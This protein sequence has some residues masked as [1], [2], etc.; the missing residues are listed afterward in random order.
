[1]LSLQN[2]EKLGKI[3]GEHGISIAFLILIS[4]YAALIIISAILAIFFIKEPK[5]EEP[6]SF[7]VKAMANV[8]KQKNI[9]LL[10]ILVL[11]IYATNGSIF[12]C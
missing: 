5:V 2:S 4:V 7:S 6:L 9:Y 11:G 1:M 10:S 3:G 12:I 8:L